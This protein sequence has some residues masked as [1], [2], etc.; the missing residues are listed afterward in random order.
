MI[1]KLIDMTDILQKF[2]MR[3]FDFRDEKHLPKR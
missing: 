3:N 2:M 1:D